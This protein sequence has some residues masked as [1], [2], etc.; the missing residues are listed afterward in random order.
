MGERIH[1][2]TVACCLDESAA[3][4]E[5]LG[6]AAGLAEQAGARL[7]VLHVVDPPG[8]FSGGR[9]ALSSDP[10]TLAAQLRE[11]GQHW[12]EERTTGVPGA[13]PVVLQDGD[14]AEAVCRWAAEAD[15][16]LLVAA[17]NRTGLAR[18][19]LGSFTGY[20]AAHAPCPVLITR[21]RPRA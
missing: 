11:D 13:E 21:P 17:A 6:L 18:K 9:T 2:H 8:K 14:P 5:A 19:L 16:D 15:C 7:L 1:I 3:A 4:E 12:L 20:L 10:E